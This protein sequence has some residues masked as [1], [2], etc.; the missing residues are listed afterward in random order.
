ML[1][2]EQFHRRPGRGLGF[3]GFGY[4]GHALPPVLP[5]PFPLGLGTGTTTADV[6]GA[7]LASA[8]LYAFSALL[9]EKPSSTRVVAGD[10]SS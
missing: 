9:P 10:F 1:A 8:P 7:P 4:A 2:H 6:C 5:L 3:A